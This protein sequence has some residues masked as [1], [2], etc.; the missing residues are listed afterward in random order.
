MTGL[1]NKLFMLW[2]YK[3]KKSLLA[4]S[5][6]SERRFFLEKKSRKYSLYV[7]VCMCAHVHAHLQ[8]FFTWREQ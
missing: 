8:G 7:C 5:V 3:N 4:I 2:E 6:I 1:N